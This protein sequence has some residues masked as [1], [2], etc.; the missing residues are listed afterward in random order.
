MLRSP[1]EC[2]RCGTVQPLIARG[3]DGDEVCG[4]CVGF[5][6]D[7]T[8]KQCGRAGNPH[9]RG[10]CAHCVLA[11]RVDALLAGPDGAI[12]PQLEPLAAAL[13]DAASPFPAIQWI[14][15]SPNTK[16]LARL[17]AEGHELTHHLLDE[18]PP[19]RNQRY[20]RQLLVHTGILEER[21]ED[22]ERIAGWL[23]H[24]LA[25]KLAAHANLARPFLNWFL[26]RRARQRA[27]TRHHPASADR[28]LRR[29]VS[30]ALDFLAWIDQRDLALADLTQEHI[31]D[32]IT[33]ATSQRRYLI[34]YF[35]KWTRSRLLTREL[36]VP[37][38]P[39]QEPQGLLDEDDRWP[40]L[41]RCLTD[42]ALPTDVRAAGSITL[43]FGPSTER[44]CHLTPEHFKLG[45]KQHALPV[46]D[47]QSLCGGPVLPEPLPVPVIRDPRGVLPQD[48]DGLA[49]V[50][51]RP[52]FDRPCSGW[53]E[54]SGVPQ[55]ALV[56]QL[57]GGQHRQVVL[58]MDS[59]RAG[60]CDTGDPVDRAARE[61][62]F[63]GRQTDVDH[64]STPDESGHGVPHLVHGNPLA[65]RLQRQSQDVVRTAPHG[66]R[67]VEG[68]DGATVRRVGKIPGMHHGAS[69]PA[70]GDSVLTGTTAVGSA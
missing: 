1:A 64:M 56:R 19:S 54:Q 3:D 29:R 21:H 49:G 43:L 48:A 7:Y 44:L 55:P 69:L 10:R 47:Q 57:T 24:E 63:L 61:Q 26:L 30:V 13:A 5:A 42:E 34:R 51:H 45:D 37:S 67:G 32:W 17:A 60:V 68:V 15:E 38:I 31:D 36:T 46:R 12:A 14:K 18:L 70:A 23:E 40:L 39:R 2:P 22:L 9:S 28:D 20:V 11:E 53:R 58:R 4:P 62:R 16:L 35:L 52:A 59:H 65:V 27:A 8:C 25:D 50:I 6:A 33:G 66:R 41:Q